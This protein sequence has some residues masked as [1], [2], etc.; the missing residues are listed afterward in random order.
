[1]KKVL[2]TALIATGLVLTGASFY[3]SEPNTP[4][5]AKADEEVRI[6]SNDE[7]FA[8]FKAD[9]LNDEMIGAKVVLNADINYE[10]TSS[11]NSPKEAPFRGEFDGNGH[12]I[13]ITVS[14]SATNNLGLFRCIGS[15]GSVLNLTTKGTINGT[16]HL[17]GIAVSNYGLI[18]NCINEMTISATGQ[19]VGGIT[20]VMN[21]SGVE[22]NHARIINCENIGN[23]T[24]TYAS[25]SSLGVAGIAGYAYGNASIISSSNYGDVTCGTAPFGLGGV[26][27]VV[28]ASS[29]AGGDVYLTNCYNGG[30]VSGDR[31]VGGILG[32]I[33]SSNA[34]VIH[35]SGCLNAG[36]IVCSNT[37]KG[38]D[39]QL[40][41]N[42]KNDSSFTIADSAILGK[43]TAQ[44][45][46]NVGDVVG[47]PNS[48]TFEGVNVASTTGISDEAKELIKLVRHFNCDADS[49]YKAQVNSALTAL[50]SEE[51]TLLYGVTYWDKS[52]ATGDHDYI[53]A[54][55]YI[56]GHSPSAAKMSMMI[57]KDAHVLTIIAISA[58]TLFV[59]LAIIMTIR[60]KRVN[61]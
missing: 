60:K 52:D 41:G 38:Y 6:I 29:S 43:I 5:P 51:Q 7:D 36:E 17:G 39:G 21:G 26:L 22:S 12:S 37:S 54:A 33:D 45:T 53:A 19:Y 58:V 18:Q 40:I 23:V 24:T 20:G 14:C 34:K 46:S 1:M 50:T 55:N 57:V 16:D 28:K 44:T 25:S 61:C 13:T 8:A 30:T 10:I 32:H 15:Q 59:G 9:L 49:A 31:Y 42:G 27:G 56:I 47:F 4:A 11:L 2:L 3:L 48:N 35:L